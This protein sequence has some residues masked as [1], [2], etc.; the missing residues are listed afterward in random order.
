MSA[1]QSLMVVTEDVLSE[2][3]LQRLLQ[4]TGYS[5]AAPM[6]RI[7][8]G[9]GAIRKNLDQYKGASTTI[10]HIVLTDL[11]LYPCP[12]AL[13]NDWHVGALPQSMLLRIAVREVEAW[14]LADRKGIADFLHAAIEKVPFAPELL[15]DPKQALFGIIRKSRKRRLVT[16]MVPLPGAHIGPLYNDRI[17]DFA[18]NYWKIE[19]AVEN[20]PSLARN[21]ARISDFLRG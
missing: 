1:T 16:D 17:C 5:G 3:V 13:M 20:A 12:P 8:R 19:A 10:P 2:T 14:L 7:A 18:L 9:N 15:N 21:I 4:N 6:F 11:D